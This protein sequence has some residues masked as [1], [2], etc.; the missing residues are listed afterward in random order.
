[1]SDNRIY[2]D[3]D[4]VETGS[5]CSLKGKVVVLKE[6]ALEA[7]FGRQLYYCTGGNG[8]NGNA[9][10]KSV[11][12]VNLKNG[13]FERCT[14][15]HVLGVLKPELLPDEEKL[16]LSQIRPPGALPLENHEPQYSGYSFLEDG[17]GSA[18]KRKPWNMWKCRSPISTGSCSV[19]GMISVSGRC[20][21]ACRSILRRRNWMRCVKDWWK[22]L[23]PCNY[24][25]MYALVV[26]RQVLHFVVFA[27]CS[28]PMFVGFY[29]SLSSVQCGMV[30]N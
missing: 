3:R 15:D 28:A 18:M 21:A 8:A 16:Q 13:E 17:C 24:R 22:I 7:G 30:L 9:L 11:F 10:G 29:E 2:T 20:G 26:E 25:G 27:V 5:G 23:A 1:M 12:L 19:T 4:C 14:R 6:S